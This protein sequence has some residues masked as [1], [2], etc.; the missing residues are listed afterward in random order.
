MTRRPM[1]RKKSAKSFRSGKKVHPK[2]FGPRPG[3]GGYRI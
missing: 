3:R 2:N 1:S